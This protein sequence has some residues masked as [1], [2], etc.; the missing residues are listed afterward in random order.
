MRAL[1][2]SLVL[3]SA[4]Y[5]LG[6]ES[7]PAISFTGEG[8]SRPATDSV[9]GGEFS[10]LVPIVI[11][12]LGLYDDDD[13]GFDV[14]HP[15]GVFRLSNAAPLTSGVISAGTSDILID[16]FRYV[17]VP[18][19]ALDAG[20]TFVVAFYTAERHDDRMIS[21]WSEVTSLSVH[22]DVSFVR[23]GRY[24]I[25]TGRLKLPINTSRDIRLGPSF[26]FTRLPEP[27]TGVLLLSGIMPALIRRRR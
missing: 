2:A 6:D 7:V 11:T 23:Q 16:R 25:D 3:L 5:S 18:D 27:N 21:L 20:D 10:P 13:D 8:L 12:H 26:L 15:I 24:Q 4:N 14:D 19:V 17:D 22:P 9:H 1:L